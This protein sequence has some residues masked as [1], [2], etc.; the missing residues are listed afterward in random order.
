MKVENLSVVQE[1]QQN[2]HDKI[3]KKLEV[4]NFRIIQEK[5]Q[6]LEVDRL[7]VIYEK[8]QKLETEKLPPMHER[9]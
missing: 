6:K 1:K 7:P 3:W 9:I 5:I 2:E 4:E 8:I